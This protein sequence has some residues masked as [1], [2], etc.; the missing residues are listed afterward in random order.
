M[1]RIKIGDNVLVG[2]GAV[3]MGGV[4]IRDNCIIGTRSVITK[5]IPCGVIA[6][7]MPAKVICTIDDYYIMNIKRGVFYPT[8]EL[9]R[10]E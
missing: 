6:A 5:D 9:T 3:I 4:T 1:A 7:G 2:C 8:V 10:E